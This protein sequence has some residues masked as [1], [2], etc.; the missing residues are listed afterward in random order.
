MKP[1]AYLL[2]PIGILI[3]WIFGMLF[4]S[5]AATEVGSAAAERDL[6]ARASPAAAAD[7]STALRDAPS[8]AAPAG[9]ERVTEVSA[10]AIERSV[11]TALASAPRLRSAASARQSASGTLRGQVARVDGAPLPGVQVRLAPL[12]ADAQRL[13]QRVLGPAIQ[14]AAD[15]LADQARRLLDAE[16]RALQG[17]SA[18]DGSF[19]F[20]VEAERVYTIALHLPGWRFDRTD[21]QGSS[22]VAGA[23]LVYV[24]SPLANLEL[25][26]TDAAG[27]PLEAAVIAYQSVS[28]GNE[29]WNF[30]AWSR[31][32]PRLE[33]SR[34]SYRFLALSA[35][36][37]PWCPERHALWLA[38]QRSA[39]VELSLTPSAEARTERWQLA[40]RPTLYGRLLLAGEETRTA[41]GYGL[42]LVTPGQSSP[43]RSDYGDGYKYFETPH[44]LLATET[45]GTYDLRLLW[46]GTKDSDL[47][48]S[49]ELVQRNLRRDFT[50]AA[51]AE[52]PKLFINATGP[53]GQPVDDLGRVTFISEMPRGGTN[54][55]QGQDSLLLVA[56][57]RF[58]LRVP[59]HLQAS[60]FRPLIAPEEG[61][62]SSCQFEHQA[63]GRRTLKLVAGQSEYT[64]QLSAPATLT[65]S[66]SGAAPA[67]PDRFYRVTIAEQ[68]GRF[69]WMRGDNDLEP[70]IGPGGA[71]SGSLKSLEPGPYEVYLQ[72]N[73]GTPQEYSQ[74]TL[75]TLP[76]QIVPGGNTV[77]FDLSTLSEL[78]VRVSGDVEGT[79]LL[80]PRLAL[81]HFGGSQRHSEIDES[82]VAVFPRVQPGE[83]VLQ[84]NGQFMLVRCPTGEVQFT[85]NPANCLR[86]QVWDEDGSMFKAGLRS[87][88]RITAVDGQTFELQAWLDAIAKKAPERTLSLSVRRD[89][90]SLQLAV[91]NRAFSGDDGG[92]CQPSYE[93]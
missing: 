20:E 62:A 36:A 70:A 85:P 49:V 21:G 16:S 22:V 30:V 26:L 33:F 72:Y 83:Y 79:M 40:P 78:R 63:W 34:G 66:I 93:P 4:Q 45:P 10:A 77:H 8:V 89:G 82:G 47:L 6:S 24:A 1:A 69:G 42:A 54:S 12:A 27:Q 31:A 15:S 29:V 17:I 44:F 52:N 3:G 39:V 67:Q 60:F 50:T 32:Q 46:K 75:M 57:G 37:E 14:S 90:A 41:G 25:D 48:G 88:D 9:G 28:R 68:G 65:V 84:L 2:L 55:S 38:E 7:P 87:G 43:E 11:R 23:S 19:S 13:S 56:P 92:Y 35:E 53:D 61:G 76:V 71:W 59:A 58:E 81:G 5:P 51:Q 64:L 86:V 74:E 80:D 73:Q 91:P 18:A